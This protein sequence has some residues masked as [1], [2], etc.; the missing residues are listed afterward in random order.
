MFDMLLFLGVMVVASATFGLGWLMGYAAGK[1]SK[2]AKNK[3]PV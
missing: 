2:H 3:E 1:L